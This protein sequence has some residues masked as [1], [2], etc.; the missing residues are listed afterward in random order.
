MTGSK[1]AAVT[2]ASIG[3]VLSMVGLMVGIVSHTVGSTNCGSG[4][5]PNPYIVWTTDCFG[6]TDSA[7]SL[8]LVLL[9]P[10][11]ISMLVG[12][13]LGLAGSGMFKRPTLEELD[14]KSHI[15]A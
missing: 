3:F 6:I 1:V 11:I 2:L 10:G 8:G 15:D 4:F 9:V 14:A 13:G 5:S 7:R 12:L